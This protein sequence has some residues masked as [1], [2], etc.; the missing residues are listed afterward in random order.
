MAPQSHYTNYYVNQA[1]SGMSHFYSGLPYQKGYGLGSFLG[2][3][4]RTVFPLFKSGAQ[5]VGREALR[6]GSHVLTDMAT[7]SDSLSTS[8]K[9]HA[10]EAGSN[11]ASSLKR[12]AEAMQGTGIKRPKLMPSAQFKTGGPAVRIA[13][14]KK[15]SS[16]GARDIFS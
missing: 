3:L 2:G 11:L 5:A 6:A 15:K 1:G 16:S 8:L 12:K 10:G 13:K 9:R 4:F 7:G 14:R